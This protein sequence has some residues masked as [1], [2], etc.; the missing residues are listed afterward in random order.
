[1]RIVSN[2]D[3]NYGQKHDLLL[4]QIKK[5]YH[6]TQENTRL[7]RLVAGLK[8]EPECQNYQ[9]AASH[10]LLAA[11]LRH[12]WMEPPPISFPKEAGLHCTR[13][14]ARLLRSSRL[15]SLPPQI[16]PNLATEAIK[17]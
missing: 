3:L 12:P 17:R 6:V 7:D 8:E 11:P 4:S 5:N 15:Y 14:K 9:H 13:N 10:L 16:S 2:P 1:M